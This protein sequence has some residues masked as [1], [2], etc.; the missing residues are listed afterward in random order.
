MNNMKFCLKI[1]L[2][3]R[4]SSIYASI[5]EHI[6]QFRQTISQIFTHKNARIANLT[7]LDDLKNCPIHLKLFYA[8]PFRPRNADNDRSILVQYSNPFRQFF[9]IP[10]MIK[11]T[12]RD[13]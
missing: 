7:T 3:I 9:N 11:A 13:W 6:C 2:I 4:T 12:I 1:K 8:S 5:D 10:A